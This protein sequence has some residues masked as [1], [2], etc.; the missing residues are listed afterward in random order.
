ML[1]IVLTYRNVIRAMATAASLL[2][3]FATGRSLAAPGPADAKLPAF[4]T[5][6]IKPHA[7]N[8]GPP[9]IGPYGTGHFTAMNA[10]LELLFE[11]AFSVDQNQISGAPDWTYTE[12]YDVD[13]KGAPGVRL[14]YEQVPPRLQRLL[15]E[16]LKLATHRQVE[17]LDGYAL[18]VASSGAKL[19]RS[20]GISAPG[21][22]N[23]GGMRF[24]NITLAAFAPILQNAVGRPVIDKTGIKGNYDI[25]L[26]FALNGVAT[27]NL[28]SIFAALQ[29]QLGL[30]LESQKVAVDMLLI[31]HVERAPA[32]K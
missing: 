29:D 4:A 23:P 22:V 11:I 9:S 10:P 13:G 21:S 20:M 32:G 8:N 28:P 31:D 14:T 12:R 16:Q 19:K 26:K 7:P 3:A 15:Q 25:D 27:A 1:P 5:A 30:V 2:I 24:Q 17:D 6:S 18:T